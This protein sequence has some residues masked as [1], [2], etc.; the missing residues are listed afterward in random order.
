MEEALAGA[1]AGRGGVVLVAGEPGIGKTRLAEEVVARAGARG[2]SAAWGRGVEGATPAFWPWVEVIRSLA[3]GTGPD[4]LTAVS[5]AGGA[6]L[7]HVVPERGSLAGAA[8]GPP[9]ALDGGTVQHRLFE[10]IARL[11]DARAR[12]QPLVVV[13]DDLHW[14]DRA[15]LEVLALLASRISATAAAVV[16]TYR[17]T[18]LRAGHPLA[19]TLAAL[20]RHQVVERIELGGLDEAE[21]GCLIAA[22]AGRPVPADVVASVAARTGGNPFFVTELART[23][24]SHVALVEGAAAGGVP[25]PVAEVVRHRLSRLPDATRALL[26][27]AAVAGSEFECASLEAAT[28]LGPDRTLD[29][30]EAA[31]LTGLGVGGPGRSREIPVQPRPRPGHDPRRAG[32]DPPGPGPRPG[33][34]SRPGAPRRRRRPR[35]RGRPPP[36]GRRPGCRGRPGPPPVLRAVEVAAGRL[37][38]EQAED[39]LRRAL[40][41][42]D[43]LPP[44]PDRDRQRLDVLLRL[45]ASLMKSNG[46]TGAETQ[47]VLTEARR[48]SDQLGQGREQMQLL[49]GAW[50]AEDVGARYAAAAA[51]ADELL[52]VAAASG[53]PADLVVAHLAAAS[54]AFSRGQP[55]ASPAHLERAVALPEGVEDPSLAV[56]A[57][58]GP[59]RQCAA[60]RLDPGRLRPVRR[61]RGAGRAVGGRRR[62]RRS[63]LHAGVGPHGARHRGRVGPQPGRGRAA[64]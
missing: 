35:P 4:V 32:S 14:A 17:S 23:M 52:A 54:C 43:Q 45:H 56:A 10:A 39:L 22:V 7:L 5:G 25:A 42:V 24:G 38:E 20:A 55:A 1:A 58:P 27:I 34:R 61:G 63:P 48:W 9:P 64:G 50:A 59:P 40:G 16:G 36:R 21:V 41:L 26:E 13:L 33:G 29:L 53:R 30:V 11:L 46:W 2:W 19:D 57:D 51:V 3:A 6:E 37:A 28:D 31:L 15:S 44:G 12:H 47:R 62:G 49:Y 18:E 60:R 8:P